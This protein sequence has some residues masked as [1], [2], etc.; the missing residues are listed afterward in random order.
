LW[1]LPNLFISVLAEFAT[2]FRF[3]LVLFPSKT[4]HFYSDYTGPHNLF[5]E[6]QGEDHFW[7]ECQSE[8]QTWSCV[9]IRNDHINL[10]EKCSNST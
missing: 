7:S 8:V 4:E 10:T 1:S 9:Y 3:F 2:S 6:W 5:T